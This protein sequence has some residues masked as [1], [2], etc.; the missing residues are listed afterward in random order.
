MKVYLK[1]FGC[2]VNQVESQ[3]A[4]EKFLA[5]GHQ[6]TQ[7]FKE[8]DLCFLNTCSVT[9]KADRDAEREIR[10]IAKENPQANLIITGCYA[11]AN[12][13]KILAA[14][15]FAQVVF[16]PDIGPALF[17]TEMDWTVKHHAGKTRAFIKIQDGCDCFCS[18]CIV[19][20]TRPQKTSKPKEIL[21]AEIKNLIAAG[22]KE[23]VLTGINI[24]NYCCPQTGADLAGIM[25]DI[26]ALP[27][28]FRIRFSSI[29]INTITDTLLAACAAAGQKFCNYFHIPLQSGSDDVLKN[30]RRRYNAAEYLS[31]LA[32][33]REK[34]PSAAIYCD[35]MAGYPSETA[36]NFEESL[37][38]LNKATFAGLH[39]FSY[40]KRSGTPAA[41]MPQIADKEIKRRANILHAKDKELRAAFA[42]SLTNTKQQF[43]AEEATAT[44]V[45][46]VL[47]NFQR[48]IVKGAHK[49][50]ELSQVK[51]ISAKDGICYGILNLL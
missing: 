36:V 49:T 2:R 16:K 32:Q 23:I 20:Y 50:G 24:G 17:D 6:I 27:G 39:V 28:D 1:T 38:F 7:N 45:S 25:P 21:L 44:T 37:K 34:I 3:A 51:I 4:L 15:P 12:K 47:A 31:R 48:C 9:H 42:A 35:I 8:A 29:E 14:H 41:E 11:M 33:I 30:M 22:Y 26:F 19:P 43:L 13:D 5:Q 46:G 10:K 40:S 18:Y